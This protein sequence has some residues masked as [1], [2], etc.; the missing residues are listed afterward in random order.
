MK[1]KGIMVPTEYSWQP[2]HLALLHSGDVVVCH[3]GG[4]FH[5]LTDE[6]RKTI[7]SKDRPKRSPWEL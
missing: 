5:L 7:E 2:T 1:K 4:Y 6:D 3:D